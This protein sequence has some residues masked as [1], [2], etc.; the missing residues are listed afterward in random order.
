[1]REAEVEY[2]ATKLAAGRVSA[3]ASTR[4]WPRHSCLLGHY[5]D[6]R[7]AGKD[8]QARAA[9][10][11]MAEMASEW[12]A[13]FPHTGRNLAGAAMAEHTSLE[14]E[15]VDAAVAEDPAGLGSAAAR[16][17]RNAR[18]LSLVAGAEVPGFPHGTF[19]ALVAAHT[20]LLAGSL[21]TRPGGDAAASDG[22]GRARRRNTLSLAAMTAEWL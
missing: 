18:D 13:L 21:K 22:N 2:F 11:A 10:S 15:M 12:A 4:W 20:A 5:A 16:L 7:R 19:G 9:K 6:L 8:W 14:W 3:P 1:M 17:V